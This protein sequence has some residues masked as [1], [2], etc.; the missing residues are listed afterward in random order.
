MSDYSECFSQFV[1][2]SFSPGT[3]LSSHQHDWSA[4]NTALEQF[5]YWRVQSDSVG[6]LQLFP[7]QDQCGLFTCIK[8]EYQEKL[9][10]INF[11]C[12]HDTEEH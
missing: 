7:L 10:E 8:E 12:Q 4:A 11:H 6:W 9:K 1:W 2:Q 5:G 3:N